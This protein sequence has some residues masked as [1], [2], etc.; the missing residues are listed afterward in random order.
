MLELE[1]SAF[2]AGAYLAS[3]NLGCKIIELRGKQIF[4]AQ[5]EAAASVFYLRSGHAIRVLD[6]IHHLMWA[7][8]PQIVATWPT[9]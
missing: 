9:Q 4:F 3:A 5:G 2:D 7:G 8:R 6:P 1:K